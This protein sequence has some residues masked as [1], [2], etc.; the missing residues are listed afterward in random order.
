MYVGEIFVLCVMLVMV[1]LWYLLCVNVVIVVEVMRGCCV[2]V[3]E[4]IELCVVDI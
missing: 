3:V 1:V 2:L 4:R